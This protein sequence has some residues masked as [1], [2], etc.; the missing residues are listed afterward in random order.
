[1]W[2]LL[3]YGFVAVIAP[4]F[5]DIFRSNCTKQGL[6]PVVVPTAV[7]APLTA[8]I[9]ADPSVEVTIDVARRLLE[10][11]AIGLVAEFELDDFHQYR[12]L[13]GLDDIGISLRLESEITSFEANRPSYAPRVV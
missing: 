11:P 4:R 12:L 9:K 13:E 3:D 8:A 10:V 1:M 6:V 5:A 2:A 7:V